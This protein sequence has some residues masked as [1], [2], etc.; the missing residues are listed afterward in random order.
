VFV[1]DDGSVPPAQEWLGD[2]RPTPPF[3]FKVLRQAN[4]G[5]ARA[6]NL[7]FS[8]S[9]GETVL[10]L[11][12]DILAPP[13]L[14]LEHVQAHRT[15]PGSVIC[16]RCP[17]KPPTKESALF[18]LLGRL[19]HDAG[20]GQ[21]D[22]FVPITVV[23]S[24]QISVERIAFWADRAVYRD[25]LVTPAAEEFELSMRLRRQGMPV[26][27]ARHISA[28]HDSPVSLLALCR[29]QYK[30]GVG[31]AE[32]ARL[33]EAELELRELA[34][35]MRASRLNREDPLMPR[36]RKMLRLPLTSGIPRAALL[37]LARTVERLAPGAD[38]FGLLYRF[39]IGLHF[40]AGVRDGWK[41][42]G[43]RQKP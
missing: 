10:F 4:A 31:C 11:D 5:P 3:L 13:Q 1:V 12:D 18:R 6:R 35:V 21:Q 37:S 39:A 16:G 17:W 36:V 27:F 41:R 26:F 8:A 9:S 23:S 32:A 25:D 7:G 38:A 15:H 19:G 43:L 22:A 33:T 28:L 30:H 40:T 34:T 2:L 24:G 20:E 14:L 42:F 29:Q